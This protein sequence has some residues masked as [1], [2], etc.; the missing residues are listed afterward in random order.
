MTIHKK[1]DDFDPTK[2]RI[3]VCAKR[4]FAAWQFISTEESRPYLNGVYIEPHKD[5]GVTMTATGGH[6][7]ASV[8]DDQAIFVGKTGWI[9]PVPKSFLTMLNRKDAG[10]LHFVGDSVY[11]T[12]NMLGYYDVTHPSFDPTEIIPRHMAVGYCQAIDGT[13]PEWK[14]V[15]PRNGRGKA[16]DYAMNGK[17]IARFT[18]AIRA[19]N[20][21]CSPAPALHIFTPPSDGQPIVIRSGAA[22]DFFGVQMP[23][24]DDPVTRLPD[25]LK[26]PRKKRPPK[27]ANDTK[28]GNAPN[29]AEAELVKS[30][31]SA[32]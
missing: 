21:A 27:P 10:H 7:L 26:L 2:R 1:N 5:G 25:W 32:A 31:Q 28:P 22:P 15:V 24:R 17:L 29:G 13:F 11:L 30:G 8:R 4:F 3:T 9:C 16:K 6:T 18:K 20:P 12:D 19:I 23:M 14:R